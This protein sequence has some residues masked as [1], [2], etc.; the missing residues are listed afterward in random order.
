MNNSIDWKIYYSDGTT[1]SNLD[2]EPIMAP[3]LNVQI[4]FTKLKDSQKYLILSGADYYTYQN[5]FGWWYCTELDMFDHLFT[6]GS[7]QLFLKGKMI[8]LVKHDKLIAKVHDDIIKMGGV[9][10]SWRH[11]PKQEATGVID[12]LER[13]NDS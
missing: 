8:D 10:D 13:I 9:K 11:L 5:D 3:R 4:I 12:L 6:I 7:N 1:F 2:G